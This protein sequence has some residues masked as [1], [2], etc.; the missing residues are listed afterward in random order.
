MDM[1]A[2]AQKNYSGRDDSLGSNETTVP[3]IT[4]DGPSSRPKSLLERDIASRATQDSHDSNEASEALKAGGLAT[5]VLDDKDT[6]MPQENGIDLD[7]TDRILPCM[8]LDQAI[9]L[10]IQHGA[11]GD[12][13]KMRDFFGG[14]IPIGGGAQISG[15][16]PLLEEELRE[17]QPR[18]QKEL[19]VGPP[20]REIDP[21]VLIWKGASVFGKLQGTNDSWIS[22]MEY[23]RLGNRLL[24]YKCL[25]NW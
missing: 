1:F 15:F 11:K 10:S 18:F 5:P 4:R 12:E 7:T 14:I 2:W 13:R 24:A 3:G 19:L 6:T 9:L 16:L 21:Q 20:P 22:A 8:P 23:D 17:A 25:W